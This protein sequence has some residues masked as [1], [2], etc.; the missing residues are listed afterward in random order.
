LAARARFLAP[1]AQACSRRVWVVIKRITGL[2]F[3]LVFVVVVIIASLRLLGLHRI[4]L[5]C[6]IFPICVCLR[7]VVCHRI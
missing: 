1:C 7:G 6:I 5:H 2:I 4:L 3:V